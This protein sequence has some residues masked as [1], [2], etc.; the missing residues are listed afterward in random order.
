MTALAFYVIADPL[1]VINGWGK[2]L[3]ADILLQDPP[4][5][6]AVRVDDQ[7][8]WAAAAHFPH[9]YRVTG[10]L[11]VPRLSM[12]PAVS[13]AEIAADG[14]AECVITGLPD[15]AQLAISGAVSGT[16]TVGADPIVITSTV[17]GALR[18]RARLDPSH[19]AWETTIHA[20]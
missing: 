11:V 17:P 9:R 5:G 16:G 15:G 18:I 6:I 2:C 19:L 20:V 14:L 8:L 13:T 4:T 7:D 3:E 12:T 1:G 10:G